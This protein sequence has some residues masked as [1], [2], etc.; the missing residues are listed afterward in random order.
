[1]QKK[2]LIIDDDV[3]MCEEICEILHDE[4][5]YGLDTAND[6]L[7]GVELIRKN[8]YDLLLLDLKV[9]GINGVDILRKVKSQKPGLKVIVLTGRPFK[10][11]IAGN[12]QDMDEESYILKNADSVLNKPYD[13]DK[14]LDK[15]KELTA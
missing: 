15:L 10:K 2:F 12:T 4:E 7:N 3:E 9:S 14:L 8:N 1:M 6:G 5:G 13:I 11:D